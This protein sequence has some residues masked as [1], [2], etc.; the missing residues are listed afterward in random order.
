[1]TSSINPKETHRTC[2]LCCETY[3]IRQHFYQDSEGVKG[4]KTACKH[5]LQ[6]IYREKYTPI[7]GRRK[8][9][10]EDTNDK[11]A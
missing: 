2:R 8:T 10:T 5:C 3:P 11:A 6:P 9:T 4:Y 1:M 7:H